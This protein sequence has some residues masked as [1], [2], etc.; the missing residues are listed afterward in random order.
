DHALFAHREVAGDER[1]VWAQ[2]YAGLSFHSPNMDTG[3]RFEF[4]R[5]AEASDQE[6]I[7]TLVLSGRFIGFLPDHYAASFETQGLMRKLYPK[8]FGYTC[9][10]AAIYRRSPP[11][12]R[13]LEIALA[14]LRRAHAHTQRTATR[15]AR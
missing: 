2:R 5:S 9:Q 10:F 3:N 11:P 1:I 14:S 8:R 7:A 12:S 15:H 6:A 4:T 13:L